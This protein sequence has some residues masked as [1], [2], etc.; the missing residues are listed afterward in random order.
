MA[1]SGAY[2]FGSGA[3]LALIWLFLPVSGRV[4]MGAMLA[5]VGG[6]VRDGR[7][8]HRRLR[9]DP[10]VGLQ[11]VPLRLHP[12]RQRD[13]LL[14]REERQ[15]VLVLL[16][17]GRP[18]RALLLQRHRGRPP[19]PVHG[20]LLRRRARRAPLDRQHDRRV[21][22]RGRGLRGAVDDR[23]RHARRRDRALRPAQGAARR[24][25][26]AAHGRREDGSADGTAQPARVR[27]GLRARG[28]ARAAA[29][30]AAD[31]ARRR[32]RPVQDAERPPRPPRGRPRARAAG[33]GAHG[34]RAPYRPG[35][36]AWAARSS[37]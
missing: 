5:M 26:R 34:R 18:L 22:R 30:V 20:L 13:D 31:A 23:L 11:G 3:T 27:G 25:D 28:R 16:R 21:R 35:R 32:P 33:G 24:P 29:R 8:A 14:Q 1:R 15:P 10:G 2:L 6:L 19:R 36:A 4:D 12:D 37:R 17:L 9:P 7:P